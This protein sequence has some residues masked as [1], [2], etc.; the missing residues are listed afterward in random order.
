[1]N[2]FFVDI[3]KKIESKIK[4][5]KKDF[6]QYLEDPSADIF[7]LNQ[8]NPEEVELKISSLKNNKANGPNSLP[9]KI[10]KEC[11]K[12]ISIPHH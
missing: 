3:P 12:E 6:K 9:T 10:M 5:S 4:Q 1:M 8:T 11:K 2:K 7:F